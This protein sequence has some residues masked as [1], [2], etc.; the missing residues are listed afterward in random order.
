MSTIHEAQYTFLYLAQLF[1]EWIMFQTKFVEKNQ[2]AYFMFN[3]FF[4]FSKKFVVYEI[5]WKNIVESDRPSCVKSLC[6]L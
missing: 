2:N 6:M 3:N 1:L 5:T 4:F